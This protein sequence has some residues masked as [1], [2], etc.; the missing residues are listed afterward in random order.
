MLVCFGRKTKSPDKIG[1]FVLLLFA[2]EEGLRNVIPEWGSVNENPIRCA[3]FFI[4]GLRSLA[5]SAQT[6]LPLN[7]KPRQKPGS[8]FH[9]RGGGITKRDP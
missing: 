4:D 7:K 3:S 8:D 1:A 9:C 6:H 5:R 2:E